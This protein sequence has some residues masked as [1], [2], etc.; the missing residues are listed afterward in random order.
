MGAVMAMFELDFCGFA[1][2]PGNVLSE[3]LNAAG[4][5]AAL[6]AGIV[7]RTIHC[8]TTPALSGRPGIRMD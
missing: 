7:L 6:G 8:T 4:I 1:S 3:C 5:D 2:Q